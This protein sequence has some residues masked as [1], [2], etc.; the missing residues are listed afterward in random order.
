MAKVLVLNSNEVDGLKVL[1]G[2][3]QKFCVSLSNL[4]TLPFFFAA[5]TFGKSELFSFPYPFSRILVVSFLYQI[6]LKLNGSFYVMVQLNVFHL[7]HK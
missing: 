2:L 3:P 1:E 6:P 4:G 7:Q 5:I